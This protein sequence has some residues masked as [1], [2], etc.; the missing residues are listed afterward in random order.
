ME[1]LPNATVRSR[2]F[3]LEFTERS[4]MPTRPEIISHKSASIRLHLR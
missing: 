4:P 3:P 2:L 1:F